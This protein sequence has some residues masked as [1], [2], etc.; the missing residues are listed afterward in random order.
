M[1]DVMNPHSEEK[2][3]NLGSQASSFVEYTQFFMREEI[4]S[5]LQRFDWVEV[6]KQQVGDKIEEIEPVKY[7]KKILK[8]KKASI[9]ILSGEAGSGKTKLLYEFARDDK[10]N[11]CFFANWNNAGTTKVKL[12]E[13]FKQVA[14]P[15]KYLVLDDVDQNP[16]KAIQFCIDLLSIN[17]HF[18]LA[19][20]N[21]KKI[22]DYLK[23]FRIDSYYLFELN[24]MENLADLLEFVSDPWLTSEIKEKLCSIVDGNPEILFLAYDVIQQQI[25][26]SNE[27]E[28]I[29]FLNNINKREDLLKKISNS[30]EN[31]AETE[32]LEFIA[33]STMYQGIDRSSSYCKSN[34]RYYIKLRALNYFYVQQDKLY[35]KPA[36]LGEYI[37]EQLLFPGNEI[38]DSFGKLIDDASANQLI[39]IISSLIILDKS[40]SLPVIKDAV[41]LVLASTQ[42]KSMD[43]V[44]IVRLALYCYELFKAPKII[45]DSVEN[46]FEL[47]ISTAEPELINQLAIFFAENG[48]YESAARAWESLLEVA[49]NLNYEGWLTVCYNNLGQVYQHLGDYDNAIECYHLAHDRFEVNGM[50]SGMIQSLLSIG[51]LYQKKG[52]WERSIEV[53]KKAIKHYERTKDANGAARTHINIAQLYKNHQQLDKAV[54]HYQTARSYLKRTGDKKRL[55]QVYGNLGLI[56]KNRSDF[57]AA[58]E[59]FSKAIEAAQAIDDSRTLAYSYNNLALVYQEKGDTEEAITNYQLSIKEL[60]QIDD[61][62][63]LSLALSNLAQIYYTKNDWDNALLQYEKALGNK[64]KIKDKKGVI[65]A[66]HKIGDVYQAKEKWEKAADFYIKAARRA[67]LM[68][69]ADLAMLL[70]NLGVVLQKQGKYNEAINAYRKAAEFMVKNEDLTGLAKTYGNMGLTYFQMKKNQKAITLLNEVLFFYLKEKTAHNIREVSRILAEIQTIMSKKEFDKIADNALNNV[71]KHGI[72]WQDK[73]IMTSQEARK[74]LNNAKLKKKQRQSDKN[75]AEKPDDLPEV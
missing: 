30:I 26:Q 60:M 12:A 54:I 21:E 61:L 25:Q 1:A 46:I 2:E 18:I 20:R 42:K 5:G 3:N 37:S 17:E 32:A 52:E 73:E 15:I 53:F 48:I 28:V 23:D 44:E 33:R 72:Y 24:K 38:A 9:I 29:E 31:Q 41:G 10:K 75:K 59:Y 68:D 34:F 36:L 58:T 35:F 70:G 67:D 43:D 13:E 63:S 69:E 57:D 74:I 27:F 19:T 65:E 11:N 6:R 49:R 22:I 62:K 39:K 8:E 64:R 51:Q 40:F 7:L 50:F 56:N 14:A 16:K 4:R 55:A 71:V 66:Y 47:D 45:L